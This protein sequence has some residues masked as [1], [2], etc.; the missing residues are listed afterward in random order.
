[1]ITQVLL[2]ESNQIATVLISGL[3]KPAVSPEMIKKWQNIVDNLK[4]I[5][6][7]KS[8]L[9]NKISS[10]EF[11]VQVSSKNQENPYKQY[12]SSKLM[13]GIYCET[14]VGKN[15]ELII[16]NAKYYSGWD[17]SKA[18][19][20]KMIAYYGVPINWSDGEIFGTLCVMDD[21][22]NKFEHKVQSLMSILKQVIED[23]LRI[24][25]LERHVDEIDVLDE[26]TQV[27]NRKYAFDYMYHMIEEYKR[28]GREFSI[29]L[30]DIDHFRNVNEN[31]GQMVGDEVLKTVADLIYDNIR[32]VDVFARTSGDE[33][34]MIAR[35]T[36]L[37]TANFIGKKLVNIFKK[38]E[39]LQSFNIGLSYGVACNK[40]QKEI[41]ELFK[42]ASSRLEDMKK[43]RR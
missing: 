28:Y 23:D 30:F 13:S 21:K 35:E 25:E 40:E 5:I 2:K 15:K 11:V 27:Y 39:R 12:D 9:I 14:V 36:P 29:I 16:D 33:F 37:D 24:I 4:D 3:D 26:L 10:K 38:D 8:A 20:D 42:L 17:N 22:T 34:V 19:D 18:I 31:Y 7:V 41:D 43:K 1:M 6:E 32:A